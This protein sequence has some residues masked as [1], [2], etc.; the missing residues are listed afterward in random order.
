MID[1]LNAVWSNDRSA[2]TATNPNH[3]ELAPPQSVMTTRLDQLVYNPNCYIQ[4]F[5]TQLFARSEDRTPIPSLDVKVQRAYRFRYWSTRLPSCS[6]VGAISH[7]HTAS[8]K[9]CHFSPHWR[10]H[11]W[12]QQTAMELSLQT[13]LSHTTVHTS[14]Y[15][16]ITV[17]M[18]HLST[19]ISIIFWLPAQLLILPFW[20]H[21][22]YVYL[23]PI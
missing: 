11:P 18:S 9:A 23:R 10:R 3:L 4:I 5:Q 1:G 17:R 20:S 12:Q 15:N 8:R 14:V 21:L 19:P 22:K 2:P 16:A 13:S 6:I 7:E